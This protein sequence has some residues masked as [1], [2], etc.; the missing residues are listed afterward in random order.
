[1]P[2][3]SVFC[4]TRK[5]ACENPASSTGHG[6]RD[7]PHQRV[8]TEMKKNNEMTPEASC[9]KSGTVARVNHLRLSAV[10]AFALAVNLL[11]C[12]DSEPLVD[13]SPAE[14]SDTAAESAYIVATRIWDEASTRSYFHVVNDLGDK[15][16]VRPSE[17]LEVPGSAR[18]FSLGDLGWFGIG[19][20]EE[21]TITKYQL[22]GKNRLVEKET[23]SLQGYGVDSLWPTMYVV[24]PTKVYHPDRAGQQLIVWNPTTMEIEGAIGLPETNRDGFLAL[25]GYGSAMRG[26]KLLFPVGWF[27]W[28]SE[29]SVLDET[30]LVVIDTKTDTVERV[31]VDERCAGITETISLPSGDSYFVSSALGAAAHELGR[32]DVA[33]CALRI[34]ADSDEFD[35]QY[36]LS[37]SDL[38][39]GAMAGDPVPGPEGRIFLRVLD[40]ELATFEEG[41]FTYELTGQPAWRWISWDPATD[42]VEVVREL[43]PAPANVSWFS[44]DGSIYTIEEKTEPF[45]ST[46]IELTADGG[47]KTRLT[48]P[49]YL[50]GVARVR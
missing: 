10:Y 21:P 38:T 8:K 13:E 31:D 50:H 46:L 2:L 11:A 45:E 32:L 1:M 47:P 44:A 20:A 40:E 30:G 12:S 23:I 3:I 14:P 4:G 22:D 17:A 25:Y 18:L 28:E 33:P 42:E 43:P 39:D 49:G 41:A 24:S 36:A 37:L 9:Q 15:T 35:A 29:D 27:D 34:G 16:Q 48:V 6:A 19:G 7:P 5:L 26:D